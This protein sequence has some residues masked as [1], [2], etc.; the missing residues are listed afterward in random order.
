[1]AGIGVGGGVGDGVGGGEE[2]GSALGEAVGGAPVLGSALWPQAARFIRTK[3][4]RSSDSVFL[5]PNPPVYGRIYH[6]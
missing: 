5:I 3:A 4:I 2:A 1:M 6:L